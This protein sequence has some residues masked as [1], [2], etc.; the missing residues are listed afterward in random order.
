MLPSASEGWRKVIFSVCVSVNYGGRGYV[1]WTS[2]GG[3]TYLGWM[4][5]VYLPW[6]G[7]GYLPWTKGRG[8]YLGH[9]VGYLPWMGMGEVPTFGRGRALTLDG[10]G[11][12]PWMGEEYL[13]WTGWGGVPTLDGEGGTYLGWGGVPTLDGG[14]GTYLGWGRG[15]YLGQ[16]EGYLFW[17]EEMVPTLDRGGYTPWTGYVMGSMFLAF[18]QE[19]FLVLI[20]VSNSS[21]MCN[22]T[23]IIKDNLFM[24][25]LCAVSHEACCKY[26]WTSNLSIT[27]LSQ[28]NLNYSLDFR[29]I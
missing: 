15:T 20:Q 1:P 23:T 9:G 13:P 21:V 10:E 19:D 16:G 11:Y 27:F 8:T 3:G 18:M 25:S 17:M 28:T 22:T 24:T 6:M 14:G 26:T 5:R 2:G 4:G 12:L 7:E 29:K